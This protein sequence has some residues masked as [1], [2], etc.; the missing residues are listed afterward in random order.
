[1]MHYRQIIAAIAI[2]LI[3]GIGAYLLLSKSEPSANGSRNI[4]M[5]ISGADGILQVNDGHNQS[6]T[7]VVAEDPT[8][9]TATFTPGMYGWFILRSKNL[10]DDA[11]RMP[12]Y[13][14]TD[15]NSLPAKPD[16]WIAARREALIACARDLRVP[17]PLRNKIIFLLLIT[18]ESPKDSKL[19]REMRIE[20]E[21]IRYNSLVAT[22]YAAATRW[23]AVTIL[24]YELG[25]DVQECTTTLKSA[26]WQVDEEEIGYVLSTLVPNISVAQ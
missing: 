10:A 6:P 9:Q 24:R 4:P 20:L 21:G 14:N 18:A 13:A 15:L 11:I 12:A 23:L 2:V 5:V 7:T 8:E 26:K 17:I 22:D 16:T 25:R 3:V 1:M 19:P